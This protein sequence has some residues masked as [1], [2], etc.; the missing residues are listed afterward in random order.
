MNYLCLKLLHMRLC[1]FMFSKL[2]HVTSC[3]SGVN[4][5]KRGWD[6]LLRSTGVLA[7]IIISHKHVYVLWDKYEILA[8]STDSWKSQNAYFRPAKLGTGR[9]GL[10][11]VPVVSTFWPF[12]SSVLTVW[13]LQNKSLESSNMLKS[14]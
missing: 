2:E 3:R 12:K 6:G 14:I 1:L 10:G 13:I 7:S 4:K 11:L 9:K 8:K 5:Q